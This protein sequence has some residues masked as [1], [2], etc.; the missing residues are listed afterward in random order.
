MRQA[1]SIHRHT[2]PLR[3]K[4]QKTI[5]PMLSTKWT[6]QP[7]TKS[8][9]SNQ[10]KINAFFINLNFNPRPL[11]TDQQVK[12]NI[13]TLSPLNHGQRRCRS[14]RSGCNRWTYVSPTHKG[15]E[16]IKTSGWRPTGPCIIRRKNWVIIR[17]IASTSIFANSNFKCCILLN[18]L[19]PAPPRIKLR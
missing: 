15:R 11:D 18:S 7:V 9:P 5:K 2:I 16:G 10:T 6:L 3:V 19:S 13:A 12:N 14:R 17:D 4:A 8:D 1:K